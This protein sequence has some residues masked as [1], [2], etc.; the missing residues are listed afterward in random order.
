MD[1]Y[2]RRHDEEVAELVTTPTGAPD[3]SSPLLAAQESEDNTIS[4]Q[5]SVKGDRTNSNILDDSAQD[6]PSEVPTANQERQHVPTSSLPVVQSE[7]SLEA[8]VFHYKVGEILHVRF[9]CV[10]L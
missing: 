6:V 9:D 10:L 7:D 2:D 8:T 4:I 1:H 3:S 5:D